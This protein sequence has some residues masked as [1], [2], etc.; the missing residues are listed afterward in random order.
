MTVFGSIVPL[1]AQQA[2]TACGYGAPMTVALFAG[3]R[4][5]G[6]ASGND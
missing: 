2:R 6:G 5:F 3:I 4:V 1:L